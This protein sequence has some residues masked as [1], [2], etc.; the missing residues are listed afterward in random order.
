MDANK[1]RIARI[2]ERS[3]ILIHSGNRPTARRYVISV[4]SP[5]TGHWY[6]RALGRFVCDPQRAVH[7]V[8][9]EFAAEY[10]RQKRERFMFMRRWEWRVV[11]LEVPR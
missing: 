7:F 6:Y 5:F 3:G 2:Q 10:M 9:D 1:E 4:R 11:P 8:S